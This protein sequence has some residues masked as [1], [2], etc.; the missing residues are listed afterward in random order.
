MPNN[1]ND[2]NSIQLKYKC[3]HPTSDFI[4]NSKG[5][6]YMKEENFV[7]YTRRNEKPSYQT[8]NWNK[9]AAYSSNGGINTNRTYNSSK[10]KKKSSSAVF[11]VI[12]LIYFLPIIIEMLTE[13][14]DNL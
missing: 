13:F 5:P 3:N 9:G 14:F 11:W 2:N 12:F 10:R 8:E 7:E 6:I 1:R 4:D